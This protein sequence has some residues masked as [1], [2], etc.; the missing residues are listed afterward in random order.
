MGCR[1]GAPI[2]LPAQ[3]GVWDTLPLPL[4][5]LLNTGA[6]ALMRALTLFLS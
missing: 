2:G 1:D 6:L 3:Q 5:P 4:P